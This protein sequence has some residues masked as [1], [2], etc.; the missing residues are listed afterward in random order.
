MDLHFLRQDF[1]EI[2]F[3]D[4]QGDYFRS[5]TTKGIFIAMSIGLALLAITSVYVLFN[6]CMELIV[7]A[8][9]PVA[10]LA[11]YYIKACRILYAWKTQISEALDREEQY[12]RYQIILSDGSFSLIQDDKETIERWSNF[13]KATISDE[14]IFLEGS[15]HIMIPRKSLKAEDYVELKKVV[16]Q[17]IK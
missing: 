2:Y 15:Q 7:F 11:F 10:F 6:D 13:L 17:K 8:S 3:K 4:H 14:Y 16:S 9:I 12:N 1:E 5:P